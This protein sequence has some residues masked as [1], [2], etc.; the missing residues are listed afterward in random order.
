MSVN[1]P[2]IISLFD[3]NPDCFVQDAYTVILGRDAD[4]S[5]VVT[6]KR[7]LG[8]GSIRRRKKVILALAKSQEGRARNPLLPFIAK[9]AVRIQRWKFLPWNRSIVVIAMTQIEGQRSLEAVVRSIEHKLVSIEGKLHS[10]ESTQ[11]VVR[12]LP[13]D[14]SALPLIE[15]TMRSLSGLSFIVNRISSKIE[16]GVNIN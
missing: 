15:H 14:N 11:T 10:N 3:A 5:G 8:K 2:S 12:A 9:E 7:M 4:A 16:G 1:I 13:S 6:Y